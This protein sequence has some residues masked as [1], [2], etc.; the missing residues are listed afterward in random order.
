V[1]G[2]GMF[3]KLASEEQRYEDLM[4]RLGTVEVQSDPSEYRKK[5]KALAEVE[6]LVARFREYKAI[7]RDLAQ[8]E[9]LAASGDAEIR[10]LA[11]EELKSLI[12]RRDAALNDLKVLLIPK[13][14]NDEKNVILE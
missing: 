1:Q 12:A 6:P 11:K 5:A 2:F 10:D 14:P 13:D 7:V 4:R 3:D 9:E 8:T